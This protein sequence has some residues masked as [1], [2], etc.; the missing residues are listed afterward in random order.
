M[1]LR[2]KRLVLLTRKTIG[3]TRKSCILTRL[4]HTSVLRVKQYIKIYWYFLFTR[5]T[6]GFTRK[7]IGIK[8]LVLR[9]KGSV[10][11][12]YA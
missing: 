1:V 7:T 10:N 5:K 11:P 6:N 2:V 4:A 8:R 3:F 9:V 12:F